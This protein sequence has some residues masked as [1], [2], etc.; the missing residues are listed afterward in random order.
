MVAYLYKSCFRLKKHNFA[1]VKNNSNTGF[2][3]GK[4]PFWK[5]TPALFSQTAM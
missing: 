1:A 5:Y 2:H 3:S 4:M